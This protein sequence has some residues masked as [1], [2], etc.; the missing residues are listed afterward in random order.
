MMPSRTRSVLFVLEA[1]RQVGC[2]LIWLCGR[3]RLEAAELQ[4]N[5]VA[6]SVWVVPSPKASNSAMGM[7]QVPAWIAYDRK[8]CR[9]RVC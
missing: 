7:S 3:H 5:A 2:N 1:Q 8:V 6:D 4:K 9:S